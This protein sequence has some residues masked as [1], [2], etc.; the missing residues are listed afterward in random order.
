M[1]T[2]KNG[3]KPCPF[4]ARQPETYQFKPS[5]IWVVTCKCGCESPPHDSKSEQ[6][7]K[8]VWNRRRQPNKISMENAYAN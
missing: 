4:C 7:A 2:K 5:E 3:L 8:R 6:A 1:K